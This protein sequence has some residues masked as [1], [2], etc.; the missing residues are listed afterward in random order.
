MNLLIAS[1]KDKSQL[2]WKAGIGYNLH[3]PVASNA[4]NLVHCCGD[5][6]KGADLGRYVSRRFMR[7]QFL[8][9]VLTHFP[10]YGFTKAILPRLQLQQIPSPQFH[11]REM[12]VQLHLIF[13]HDQLSHLI[14]RFPKNIPDKGGGSWIHMGLPE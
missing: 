6:L 8:D 12:R 11:S 3:G 13:G 10:L 2:F 4:A 7:H 5:K 9:I 14:V 1:L